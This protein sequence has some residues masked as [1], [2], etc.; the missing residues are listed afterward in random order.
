MPDVT[1]STPLSSRT[2]CCA[3]GVETLNDIFL[4][5]C[6]YLAPPILTAPLDE[7]DSIEYRDDMCYLEEIEIRTYLDN[8]NVPIIGA[9]AVEVPLESELVEPDICC[10][11]GCKNRDDG[12][13][14]IYFLDACASSTVI[15]QEPIYSIED[16]DF[17]VATIVTESS[18]FY[19]DGELACSS[20]D[21]ITRTS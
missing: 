17:C 15:E 3:I 6:N 7:F 13:P 10:E 1:I 18:N 11:K 12:N 9:I 16:N 21:T 2:Q 14:L 4:E 5:A 20:T 8:F 19:E